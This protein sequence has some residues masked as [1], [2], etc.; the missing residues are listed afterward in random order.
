MDGDDG[1]LATSHFCRIMVNELNGGGGKNWNPPHII[2]R[3]P[4][5]RYL[6]LHLFVSVYQWL[7][8]SMCAYLFFPLKSLEGTCC[9]MMYDKPCEVNKAM[10]QMIPVFIKVYVKASD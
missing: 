1:R 9:Y 3:P 4:S 10:L 7:L 2:E 6:A 5:L 8:Y